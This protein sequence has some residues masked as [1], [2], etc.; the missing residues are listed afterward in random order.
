M[1]YYESYIP[2]KGYNICQYAS[3]TRGYRHTEEAKEK[4]RERAKS[5]IFNLNGDNNPMY[6]KHLSEEHKSAISHYLKEQWK[7]D[8][9]RKMQS[10]RAKGKNNYFY[11][12]HFNGEL[13]PMYG[14]HH[15]DETKE[16]ISKKNKGN[17][18]IGGVIAIRCLE[19]G[20]NFIS[21]SEAARKLGV[22]TCAIKIAVD[23]PNRTCKGYHFEKI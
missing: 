5:R 20:E 3:T 1:D 16:K 12:K 18:N 13:N 22:Y 10:E 23:N 21:M 19:T 7:N 6:G 17:H 15:T 2:S 11:D 4:M 14:K 8:D 9:Y